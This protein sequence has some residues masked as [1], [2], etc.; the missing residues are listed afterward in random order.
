VQGRSN[1]QSIIIDFGYQTFHVWLP[2]HRGAAAKI[3]STF[4]NCVNTP[5]SLILTS[6]P[7]DGK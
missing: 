5:A 3:I 7:P 6:P 2:S 1:A 4:R